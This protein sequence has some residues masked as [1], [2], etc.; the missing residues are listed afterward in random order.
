MTT[1]HVPYDHPVTRTKA[2]DDRLRRLLEDP[3]H[4]KARMA[5]ELIDARACVGALL[6]VRMV[7]GEPEGGPVHTCDEECTVGEGGCCTTCGVAHGEACEECGGRG[8]HRGDC[9]GTPIP[10][11]L[12]TG[13][14]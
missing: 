6:D 14:A 7:N 5:Q 3:D 1:T 10:Y 8:F 4:E 2:T 11:V 9:D 12:A 13:G